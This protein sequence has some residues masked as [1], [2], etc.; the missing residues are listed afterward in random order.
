MVA[1]N[2]KTP[3]IVDVP[4]MFGTTVED[5]ERLLR[6]AKFCLLFVRTSRDGTAAQLF[7]ISKKTALD[8]LRHMPANSS[9]PSELDFNDHRG[10]K[11]IF[12]GSGAIEKAAAHH[13][14]FE[15]HA[16]RRA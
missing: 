1:P 13:S 8:N 3:E 9:L 4:S 16:G 12:G 7:K 15:K 5:A 6:K 11:L 2:S 14:N 10:A